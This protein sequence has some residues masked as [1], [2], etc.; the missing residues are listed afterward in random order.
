MRKD[1]KLIY[2][3]DPLCGWCYAVIPAFRRFQ[4]TFP[5]VPIEV[6]GGGLFSGD[7]VKPY[8]EMRD[9]IP[10]TFET[11]QARSGR[12]ASNA[13]FSMITA[14]DTGPI[15]SAGPIQAIAQ[16][17]A[18]APHR[19]A[20]FAHALQEAHF[21]EARSMNEAETYDAVTDML[22]LPRLD[23]SAILAADD[24]DALVRAQYDRARALELNSYPKSLVVD[25]Q[26]RVL[27]VI[28]GIYDPAAFIAAFRE[29]IEGLEQDEG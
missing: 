25:G 2:G 24:D 5:D 14:P 9:Y 19:A 16:V 3:H 26:D 23:T 6:V 11:I 10:R 15:A 1:I 28:D 12:R 21:E 8:G 29:I 27:G 22:Q 7:R 20:S 17:A 13:F 18:K 4:D